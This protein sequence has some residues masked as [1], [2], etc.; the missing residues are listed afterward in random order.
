MS[1]FSV[2][3]G[4]YLNESGTTQAKIAEIANVSQPRVSHWLGEGSSPDL[5]SIHALYRGLKDEAP[6]WANR[7]VVAFLRDQLPAG[8]EMEVLVDLAHGKK[9]DGL[10]AVAK[11]LPPSVVEVIVSVAKRCEHKQSFIRLL[12]TALDLADDRD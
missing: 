6:E 9:P 7:L 12:R 5:K 1:H 2:A 8:A 3:L 10:S 4:A 11:R